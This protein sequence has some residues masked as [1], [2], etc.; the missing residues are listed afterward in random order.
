M[1]LLNF[2][3]G[4]TTIALI[5]VPAI[6]QRV[7]EEQVADQ[8]SQIEEALNDDG[9]VRSHNYKIDRID[10]SS[11]DYLTLELDSNEDYLITAVCDS[12]CYDIDLKL[13]DDNDNLIDEDTKRDDFPIVS[14]TPRRTAE[15]T[16]QVSIYSCTEPYCYYGVGVFQK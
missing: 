9:L 12:D 14:V 15:F 3:L 13:Y 5:G 8:L 10:D 6:A 16:I 11:R 2:F 7:Y 4:F 1:K